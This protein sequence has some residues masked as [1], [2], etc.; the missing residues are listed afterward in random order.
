MK[1]VH[2]C[3]HMAVLRYQVFQKR[4]TLK[5]FHLGDKII[6]EM[7][8]SFLPSCLMSLFSTD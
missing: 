6:C 2:N 5:P 7:G 4:A 8:I 3:L 1:K